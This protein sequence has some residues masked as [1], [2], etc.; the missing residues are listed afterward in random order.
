ML[1]GVT[2]VRRTTKVRHRQ[3]VLKDV[4][5]PSTVTAPRCP[6]ATFFCRT[7]SPGPGERDETAAELQTVRVSTTRQRQYKAGAGALPARPT[8][9]A[10]PHR[11]GTNHTAMTHTD[12]CNFPVA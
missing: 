9:D 5:T 11:Q 7:E 2:V 8:V 1:G 3:H 12:T 4:L 6:G 10:A